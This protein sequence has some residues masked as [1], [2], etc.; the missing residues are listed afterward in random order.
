MKNL[1]E[2][3]TSELLNVIEDNETLS[4]RLYELIEQSAMDW[5]GE[6]LEVIRNSLKDW[7]IGF[8]NYNFL[9]VVDYEKFVDSLV[10]YKGIFGLS[11]KADK[12]LSHCL[13]L[14]WSNL[15]EYYAE[16]LKDLILDE[17][18]NSETD[19]DYNNMEYYTEIYADQFDDYLINDDGDIVQQTIVGHVA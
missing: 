2:L 19:I 16:R 6:K 1:S 10:E 8:Y 4:N 13:K 12:L 17:E 5:V 14:R 7:S 15:F 3:S 11:D 9:D 18:F